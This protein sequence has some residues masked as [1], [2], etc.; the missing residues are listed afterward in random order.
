MSFSKDSKD[1]SISVNSELLKIKH[2][3][4]D[5][6]HISQSD[7][8]FSRNYLH[9]SRTQTYFCRTKTNSSL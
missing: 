6:Q 3:I 7:L 2:S 9:F 4:T 1:L 5:Y 8:F